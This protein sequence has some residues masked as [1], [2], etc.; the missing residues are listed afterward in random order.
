MATMRKFIITLVAAMAAATSWAQLGL[1]DVQFGGRLGYALGGTAPLGMPATIRSL[2]SFSPGASISFGFDA[3]KPIQGRWGAMMGVH[4]ENK[5][6]RTDA[7]TKNYRMEITRGGETLSG[8]FTGKVV[9]K[10]RQ[11][12]FTVP[13]QAVYDLSSRVSLKAGPYVSIVASKEFSGYAYDGYL[14]V[15]DPTG[16]KVE[17]GSEPGQRGDYDFSDDMRKLQ[18]G[19]VIGADVRITKRF[20]VYADLEWGLSSIHKSYFKTIEQRLYPIYGVV[21]ITYSINNREVKINKKGN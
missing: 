11:W 2:N 18:Y 12:M 8:V 15:G 5:A 7:N 3:Y 13:V 4:L 19:I 9:T 14:R 20:G 16:V 10:V 17:L 21:G 6:M 1:D